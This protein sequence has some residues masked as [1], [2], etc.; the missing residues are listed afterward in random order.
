[1]SAPRAAPTRIPQLEVLRVIATL[2]VFLFHL[3]TEVPLTSPV[4]VLGPSL[5]QLPLFGTIGVVIF[6]NTSDT[7]C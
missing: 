2:S 5:A 3:W 1:M 6:N 4:P 7:F